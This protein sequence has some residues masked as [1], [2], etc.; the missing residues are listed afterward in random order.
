MP[1]AVASWGHLA[2]MV[3]RCS[4]PLA[5][6]SEGGPRAWKALWVKVENKSLL[7]REKEREFFKKRGNEAGISMKK[8]G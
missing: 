1:K 6:M 4:N 3:I 5:K 8:R 2:A 7:E